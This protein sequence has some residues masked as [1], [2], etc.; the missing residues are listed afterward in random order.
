MRMT[1]NII[2]MMPNMMTDENMFPIPKAML[3]RTDRIPSL[4]LS[5]LLS[6]SLRAQCTIRPASP[7]AGQRT[8]RWGKMGN[9]PL[10]ID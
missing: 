10:C 2:A 4:A 7:K 1:P 3:K 5:V 9:I 6:Q 8:Q